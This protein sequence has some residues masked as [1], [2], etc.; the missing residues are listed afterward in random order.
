MLLSICEACSNA[1]SNI[2]HISAMLRSV[3]QIL[4][5]VTFTER[6]LVARF[7]YGW[8]DFMIPLVSMNLFF[9]LFAIF[10]SGVSEKL[11]IG[12]LV[13]MDF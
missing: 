6:D 12:R 1:S 10:C 7:V 9:G 13:L 8:T 5:D 2:I 4:M 3:Y 11:E